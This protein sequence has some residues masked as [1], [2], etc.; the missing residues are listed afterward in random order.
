MSPSF[1]K[2][3][4]PF[5]LYVLHVLERIERGDEPDPV[6]VRIKV[7]GQV[8]KAESMLAD[9]RDWALAKYA[10]I[11]WAEE[12]L[13]E[14]PWSGSEYF[15]NNSLEFEVFGMQEFHT[16]FYTKARE[17]AGNQW[18]DALETFYI[19]VVLGFRGL[20]GDED[21]VAIFS[22]ELHLPPSIDAW[23]R[24]TASQI[25]HG[26]GRRVPE[27]PVKHGRGA[28]PLWARFQLLGWSAICAVLAACVGVLTYLWYFELGG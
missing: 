11:S 16:R 13:K 26:Q 2:A 15:V 18:L 8:N 22:G 7:L 27:A 12:S 4:D 10:L 3:V 28:H 14:A 6:D 19:C 5:I 9:I 25:K 21:M 24:Q 23:A 20:Y 1:A 17:A